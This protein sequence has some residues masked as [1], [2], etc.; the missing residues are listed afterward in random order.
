MFT[1]RTSRPELGHLGREAQQDPLVGL[2]AQREQVRLGRRGALAEEHQRRQLEL[3]RDLGGAAGEALAGAQVERHV[4]PAPVL[5]LE[6]S[7][8]RRS[9]RSS[10]A[11]TSSSSR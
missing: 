1:L 11:S 6:P 3:D 2:D 9:R 5:D 7:A 10:R 4:G 8:R